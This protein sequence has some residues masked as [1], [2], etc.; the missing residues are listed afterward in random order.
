MNLLRTSNLLLLLGAMLFLFP[1]VNYGYEPTDISV[2]TA[3]IN[4][5]AAAPE[6]ASSDTQTALTNLENWLKTSPGGAGWRDYLKLDA[7]KAEIASGDKRDAQVESLQQL[8][9]GAAGLNLKPFA[10]LRRALLSPLTAKPQD[11]PE[12]IRKIGENFNP[13]ND[14]TVNS[15]YAKLYS[16]LMRLER[17]LARDP[18]QSAHWKKYLKWNEMVQELKK[19]NKA[20]TSVLYDAASLYT[21]KRERGEGPSSAHAGISK[22]SRNFFAITWFG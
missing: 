10:Q 2:D 20:D 6:I 5:A 8:S 18:I 7:L 9:S 16:A 12:L 21:R 22:T 3:L 11:M 15:E 1:T 19:G 14:T 17:F 4:T 13:V